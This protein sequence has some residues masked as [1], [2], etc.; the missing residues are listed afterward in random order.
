MKQKKQNSYLV[1]S[2]KF[3]GISC[4]AG[5]AALPIMLFIGAIVIEIAI[6]GAFL[7]YLSANSNLSARASGEALITAK[8]GIEDAT[9]ALIKDKDFS[10]TD[11]YTVT[12][13]GKNANVTVT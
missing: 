5:I 13:N 1:I 12:V 4:R 3:P 2:Y 8:A 7:A 10:D 11:G 9:L 6:V